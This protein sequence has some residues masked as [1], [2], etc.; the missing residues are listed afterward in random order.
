[1]TLQAI[2]LW[3][4]LGREGIP[5]TH[6]QAFAEI[7]VTQKC[8]ILTRTPGG[9]GKVLLREGYDGKGFNIKAKSCNWGPMAG[10]VCLD[11][12]FNKNGLAGA[13][14]NLK[15]NYKSLTVPYEDGRAAGTQP[16]VIS[17]ARR[18]WLVKKGMLTANLR[19]QL[20]VGVER[21][22]GKRLARDLP[23]V[24]V[25]R[26]ASAPPEWEVYYDRAAAYGLAAKP[27]APALT[28][29]LVDNL[30]EMLNAADCVKSA[31]FDK[32]G[33][34]GYFLASQYPRRDRGYKFEGKYYEPVLAMTNP[35]PAYTKPANRHRNAVTGDYDLFAVWPHLEEFF[36]DED[37]RVGGMTINIEDK[38]IIANEDALLGNIS[39][40]IELIAQLIN[41]KIPP[42]VPGEPAPNRL[43]HSDEA[44]RPFVQ[45]VEF[46]VA[47]FVPNVDGDHRPVAWDGRADLTSVVKAY[48]I[49]D[50]LTFREFIMH[51][52]DGRYVPFLNKGWMHQLVE[53][54]IYKIALVLGEF[55][56]PKKKR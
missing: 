41:S 16:V 9:V 21:A 28:L 33:Y 8:A 34:Q 13:A 11:P 14:G 19:G 27:D 32:N 45:E 22:D 42:A 54:P 37:R 2:P 30:R 51:C 38:T 44:G 55:Q 43:F 12:L 7:A 20:W 24:L 26:A 49:T 25:P 1:M 40:R 17:E 15:E 10:F 56:S 6:A 53:D 31:D 3:K 47:A 23:Y 5:L 18:L 35:H 50:V 48:L 29:D 36:N 52:F 4:T 39:P 46:P